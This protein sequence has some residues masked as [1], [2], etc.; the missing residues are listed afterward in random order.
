MFGNG[1]LGM[2]SQSSLFRAR[3]FSY[4]LG[5][6]FFG[7]ALG[8]TGSSRY[9]VHAPRMFNEVLFLSLVGGILVTQTGDMLSVFYLTFATHI[10]FGI[11]IWGF[12]PESLSPSVLQTNQDEVDAAKSVIQDRRDERLSRSSV[13]FTE[14]VRKRVW[15]GLKSAA[16]FVT[17]LGVFIPRKR[18]IGEHGYER[19]GRDWNLSYVGIASMLNST[20]IVSGFLV[21]KSN[22]M[23]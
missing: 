2:I 23:G 20:I 5:M 15:W 10:A 13:T 4:F 9:S 8:P 12:L 18:E 6:M 22:P 17:P 16:T 1:D 3:Y 11:V 14:M 19:G 7:M 21:S